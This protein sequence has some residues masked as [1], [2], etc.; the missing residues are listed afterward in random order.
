M[1]DWAG[2]VE[3]VSLAT[4]PDWRIRCADCSDTP[5]VCEDY[6]QAVLWAKNHHAIPITPVAV[7]WADSY[8]S[9]DWVYNVVA[10]CI[11][12]G[13]LKVGDVLGAEAGNS[14]YGWAVGLYT[15]TEPKL[16]TEY[17]LPRLSSA[18]DHE[19]RSSPFV[20]G[21]GAEAAPMS[22]QDY[23]TAKLMTA[24]QR[25]YVGWRS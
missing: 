12:R 17:A 16:L 5:T 20:L 18:V 10:L 7:R 9:A 3:R 21:S 19:L 25:R 2:T 8:P 11:V 4:W 6:E 1:T 23:R 24:Y 14:V 13:C 15:R 22:T